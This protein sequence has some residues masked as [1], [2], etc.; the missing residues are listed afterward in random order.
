MHER[1]PRIDWKARKSFYRE[2][3]V[4]YHNSGNDMAIER[5]RSGEIDEYAGEISGCVAVSNDC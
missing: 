2:K 5:G 4:R 3:S 1:P